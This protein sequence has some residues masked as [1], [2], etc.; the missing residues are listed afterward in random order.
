MIELK[1]RKRQ[2]QKRDENQKKGGNPKIKK[3][4]LLHELKSHDSFSI[5]GNHTSTDLDELN[6]NM[7]FSQNLTIERSVGKE[8][9]II[10]FISSRS[11][12]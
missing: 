9:G 6:T 8:I 4:Q 7:S 10:V 12:N 3:G 2:R 1:K 11:V 5:L